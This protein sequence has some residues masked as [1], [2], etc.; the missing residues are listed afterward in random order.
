MEEYQQQEEEQSL[1]E[2]EEEDKEELIEPHTAPNSMLRVLLNDVAQ[3]E[4][5]HSPHTI[6]LLNCLARDNSIDR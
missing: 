4:E 5:K 1:S 3:S 2:P 6:R